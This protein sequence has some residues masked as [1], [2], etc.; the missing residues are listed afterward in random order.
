MRDWSLRSDD[1]GDALQNV[2]IAFDGSGRAADEQS[3]DV[4]LRDQFLEF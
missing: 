4:W 1:R 2:E 3:V